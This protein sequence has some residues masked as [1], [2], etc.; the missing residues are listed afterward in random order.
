MF[1]HCA[2]VVVASLFV[3]QASASDAPP[4]KREFRGVWVATVANIDWPSKPGL[5]AEKQ[6]EEL[7]AIFDKAV[8]LRLNAVVF[9]VRPMAD[10]LYE[11]KLEP[12]SEF[13]TGTMG[14]SPGYDPL[15]FA[16]KEAHARGLELHAWF[17]PYRARTP[18]AKS[19]AP[20]DHITKRRPDLAK[21]YGKH[22][23]MNPTH[24]DVQDQS[25]AVIL[26]VVKRYDVDGVH[27]DDYFYP[28]KEKDE[29]TGEIIPFPDDD[30]WEKYQK[31]G[32]KLKRDDWRRDAVNKFVERMYRDVK[33]VK[34][35]VKVG[36]SPFGIWRPGTPP[37]IAGF[38]QYAELYADARLWFN[39]GWVDYYTPQLY[40][41]IAQE[42]QSF[43]KLLGWWV[44]E[45][46]KNRHLWPGLTPAA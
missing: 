2:G 32:G 28:Y 16:V 25:I 19:A 15:A 31:E 42:K 39:Q 7:I 27:I 11:S 8:H 23:W 22:Y 10:S 37:G 29:K 46:S 3:A 41:A 4:L 40:W 20:D 30:T 18:T 6:R 33:A 43:P 34:P 1:R 14:K 12:W 24:T 44:G 38:D 13:L 17:N 36:I 45:N 21:P 5:S 35:W 9:Q 26:D